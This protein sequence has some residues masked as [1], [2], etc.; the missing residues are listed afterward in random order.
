M[1]MD[2]KPGRKTGTEPWERYGHRGKSNQKN[3]QEQE[4]MTP[5]NGS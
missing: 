3:H 2:E 4:R 1:E 5:G